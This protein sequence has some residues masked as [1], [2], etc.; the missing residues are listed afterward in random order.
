ML[1]RLL[2]AL[3]FL[4]GCPAIAPAKSSAPPD[5]FQQP[6]TVT[7]MS[8]ANSGCEPDCPRWIAMQG[9]IGPESP[10]RLRKVL[11][12]VKGQHVPVLVHSPGGSVEAGLAM[13]RMIRAA[14]LD[15]AVAKTLTVSPCPSEGPCA[16]ALRDLPARGHALDYRAYCFSSCVFVLAGGIERYVDDH[17]Y[18]GVHQ[19]TVTRTQPT[20]HR[21]Y[22]VVRQRIGRKIVE[23]SRTL[24][25]ETTTRKTW[26]LKKAPK[27]VNDTIEA[28]FKEMGMR[29]SLVALLLAT[30]ADSM[31][32]LNWIELRGT[33]LATKTIG[34][35]ALLN[36]FV[37][38]Q[39]AAKPYGLNPA[40]LALMRIKPGKL[41]PEAPV[42]WIMPATLLARPA[43]R[44]YHLPAKAV[45]AVADSPY[46]VRLP[47]KT[48]TADGPSSS[49]SFPIR[50][51][52]P[53]QRVRASW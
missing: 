48:A 42:P 32:Y 1:A 14:G 37:K 45:S 39:L 26:K 4:C 7:L 27:S 31:H 40:E 15:V 24:I 29:P 49:R 41:V 34:A 44:S 5:I 21:V 8:D 33:E 13:G 12:A 23:V 50:T 22:R 46:T 30:P 10:G 9:K 19:V 53:P 35:A 28:Y 38:A 2:L 25:K 20:I 52:P 6:M 18:A 51:S 11:N 16:K 47:S 3:I 17:A 36:A 43:T